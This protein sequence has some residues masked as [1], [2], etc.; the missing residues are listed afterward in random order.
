M[1]SSSKSKTDAKNKLAVRI[2]TVRMDPYPFPSCVA[3]Q[4]VLRQVFEEE[5]HDLV[6]DHAMDCSF[7]FPLPCHNSLSWTEHEI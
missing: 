4:M 1:T 7:L 3:L 6:L 5:R 2:V